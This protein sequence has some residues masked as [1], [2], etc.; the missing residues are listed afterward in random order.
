[1]L[2]L[3][4][5]GG[6]ER[7]FKWGV[8][9]SPIRVGRSPDAGLPFDTMTDLSVSLM[10]AELRRSGI[11]WAISDLGS[12]NG[13]WVNGHRLTEPAS[14]RVGDRIELGTG[15]PVLEVTGVGPNRRIRVLLGGAVAVALL[16]GAVT[17]FMWVRSFRSATDQE[18]ATLQN[19]VDSLLA[20]GQNQEREFL[21]LREGSERE[22]AILREDLARASRAV[23]QEES[24]ADP[25]RL[26]Q[27]QR[28][29]LNANARLERYRLAATIDAEGIEAESGNAVALVY[30]RQANGGALTG[31]AFAVTP[32]GV[33]VTAGHVADAATDNELA[34]RFSN[35]SQTWRASVLAQSSDFDLALLQVSGIRGSVPTVSR[36][37]QRSDSI[38]SGQPVALI[39]FPLGG[40]PQD[41]AERAQ[42]VRPVVLL[43]ITEATSRDR[44]EFDTYGR[45]GASGS[46]VFDATGAVIGVLVGGVGTGAAGTAYAVPALAVLQL[47]Q[48]AG[49]TPSSVTALRD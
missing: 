14:M 36:L 40:A 3:R 49:V 22:L 6:R 38:G 42:V 45:P 15:G 21:A 27:L 30:A 23:V 35:S 16:A 20:A 32:G 24:D 37:N 11:G 8:A 48:E 43:G 31:T 46:P 26:A 1:M 47:M 12:T 17:G 9:G 28:E 34:V 39:G 33:L 7:T 29:L 19:T 2:T 25:E 44:I 41:S 13:T 5:V 4:E 18:R 10:H